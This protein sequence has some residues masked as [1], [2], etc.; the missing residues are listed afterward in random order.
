WLY[1]VP[2]P[3]WAK[4]C[5]LVS[6][7]TTSNVEINTPLNPI[8]AL[9]LFPTEQQPTLYDHSHYQDPTIVA[10]YKIAFSAL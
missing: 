3:A 1:S 2:C 4:S 7:D 6:K 8:L 9:S 5:F 10:L